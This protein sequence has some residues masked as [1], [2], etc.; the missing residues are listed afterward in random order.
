LTSR[1]RELMR[2]GRGRSL[3]HTIETLNPLLRG[4]I[5]YFRLAQNKRLLEDLDGWVRR[6]NV[7]MTLRHLVS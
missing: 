6:R 4:G 2:Q 5:S 1:V 7:S 3:A